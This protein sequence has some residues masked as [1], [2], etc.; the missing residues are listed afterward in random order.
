MLFN[1]F[2][3]HP[4]EVQG[5]QKSLQLQSQKSWPAFIGNNDTI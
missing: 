3:I 1:L 5:L 2:F 4:I